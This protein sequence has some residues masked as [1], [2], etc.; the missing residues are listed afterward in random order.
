MS[1]DLAFRRTVGAEGGYANDPDDPGGE[2]MWG[3]TATVARAHGYGGPMRDMPIAT[4]KA[5]YRAGYWDLIHL[6]GVDAISPA[7]AA[8]IF[9]TAVNCGAGVPV[10]FLQRALNAF[11]RQAL[12]YPDLVVDGLCGSVTLAALRA[13]L[14]KRGAAGEKVMLA[15]LN[16][17]QGERYLDIVEGR[18]ASEAFVF[19]WFANR[20]TI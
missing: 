9:D 12:D 17:Q 13:Y 11:N 15:A 16:A 1:F 20:I 3:I 10:K 19:G 8:Q 14:S 4:A 6:D 7:I 18:P 2:T 5:I